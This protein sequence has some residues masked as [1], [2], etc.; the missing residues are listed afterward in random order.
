MNIHEIP[1]VHVLIIK[2]SG[3]TD[4]RGSRVRIISER[5]KNSVSLSYDYEAGD[6]VRTAA[7]YLISK[8]FNI[9]FK[10]EGKEC[11][12]IITDTFQSIK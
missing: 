5:F 10:A 12:Y 3:A 1:N 8:G 9:L 7:K 2:Y 6:S 11:D 4:T